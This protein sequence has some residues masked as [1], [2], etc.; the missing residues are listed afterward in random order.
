M[1]YKCDFCEKEYIQKRNLTRHAQEKHFTNKQWSCIQKKCSSK[2]FRRSNLVRHL[3]LTHRYS[4]CKAR[5]VALCADKNN[6]KQYAS[7]SAYN[8]NI[9][10]D[11]IILDLH[12]ELDAMEEEEAIRAFDLEPYQFKS[13]DMRHKSED[14][15]HKSEDM[16]QKSEDM[17]HKSEDMR[18]KSEHN[19]YDDEYSNDLYVTECVDYI[20]H[21]SSD[22][23]NVEIRYPIVEEG[24]AYTNV[25][26]NNNVDEYSD[27]DDDNK[28]IRQI[29][30]YHDGS[31]DCNV[32]SSDDNYFDE[33][34]NENNADIYHLTWRKKTITVTL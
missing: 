2:F 8:W 16:R 31:S 1:P 14:M 18:H 34:D 9:I 23:G 7:T 24:K 10:L 29:C 15:R 5:R 21:N 11:E 26:G 32:L 27:N 22:D 6:H 19:S 3:C 25:A 17:R 20:T 13:E 4:T 33:S 30:S 12:A 28:E